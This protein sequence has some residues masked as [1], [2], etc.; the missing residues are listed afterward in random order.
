MSC[1][2][3][4]Y[5]IVDKPVVTNKE[6]NLSDLYPPLLKLCNNYNIKPELSITTGTYRDLIVKFQGVYQYN[7]QITFSFDLHLNSREKI[8][9]A[10]SNIKF[11]SSSPITNVY[12]DNINSQ[13]LNTCS[14]NNT[15][16]EHINVYIEGRTEYKDAII[17]I[18]PNIQIY[19]NKSENF[20]DGRI[21][22]FMIKIETYD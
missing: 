9:L 14:C 1:T 22:N 7:F 17:V 19:T 8:I 2:H 16:N 10:N 21:D 18:Y 11:S 6:N 3:I 20:F 4:T 15:I 13:K 12:I 5:A